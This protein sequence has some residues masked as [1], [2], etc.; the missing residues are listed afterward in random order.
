[1][2]APLRAPDGR[3]SQ[4]GREVV[5]RACLS[6]NSQPHSIFCGLIRAGWILLLRAFSH[7]PVTEESPR[8][9]T[10]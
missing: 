7:G 8:E 5:A 1:M 9:L 3:G 10:C 4:A 6:E 2:P